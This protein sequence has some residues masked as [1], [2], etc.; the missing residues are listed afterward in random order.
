MPSFLGAYRN[1]ATSREQKIVRAINSVKAQTYKQWELIIVADGCRKTFEMIE[2]T[3]KISVYLINKQKTYSGQV[4]NFGIAKAEYENILYLDTDDVWGETH[5]ENIAN[6]KQDCDW[7]FFDDMV[8]TKDGRFYRRI[9]DPDKKFQN[10]TSNIC[11]KKD[12]PVMWKDGYLHDYLFI[13][14]LKRFGRMARINGG[15]Y[16]TCHIPKVLDI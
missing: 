14:D 11:H 4:R 7:Y 1:A 9:C 3:D 15:E 8:G 13:Q 6:Q 5:L 12:L 10:G 2:P 16:H